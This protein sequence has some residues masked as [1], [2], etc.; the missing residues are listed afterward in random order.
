MNGTA[1][2]FNIWFSLKVK[3]TIDV[4]SAQRTLIGV[5]CEART[6][7]PSIGAIRWTRPAENRPIAGQ[8]VAD[9]ETGAATVSKR[10][11]A[12]FATPRSSATSPER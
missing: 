11:L 2:L 1:T 9:R 8:S 6:V 4:S 12:D 5:R 7:R 3:S 10:R